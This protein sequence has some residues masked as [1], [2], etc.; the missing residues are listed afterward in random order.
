[1]QVTDP[2]CGRRLEIDQAHAQEDYQGWAYFFCS[3]ECHRLFTTNPD[4]Y[5]GPEQRI[6]P[7]GAR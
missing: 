7:R 2:V 5:L 3:A 4:R 1:M 6:P